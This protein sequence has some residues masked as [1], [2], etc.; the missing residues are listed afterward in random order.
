MHA[1]VLLRRDVDYV[2]KNGAV[3][4]VDEFK[5][6]IALNRR[7][8]AGLHTAIEVKERVAAKRQGRILG[9][10]T[11]QHLIGLY[12]RVC[13][14]TGTA[15]TQA[16]EFETIYEMPVEVIPTNRPVIRTTIRMPYSQ[17]G[18]TRNARFSEK[19]GAC[20]PADG[21]FWWEAEASRSPNA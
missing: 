16:L 17:P 7:W 5:G 6:R 10:V 13:G 20:T 18:T 12:P 11:L 15:A 21:P 4:M 19:S 2:V 14:M 8:P 9:S 3:E 1:H